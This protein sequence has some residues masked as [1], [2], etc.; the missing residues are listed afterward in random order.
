[1][2]MMTGGMLVA[3]RVKLDFIYFTPDF[4]IIVLSLCY[5]FAFYR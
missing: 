4:M 2:V 3:L 5:L 1:V